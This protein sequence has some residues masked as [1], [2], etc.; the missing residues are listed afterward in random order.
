M[1]EWNVN[2]RQRIERAGIMKMV[3]VYFSKFGNTRRVAE[4]MGETLG[5]AGEVRVVGIDELAGVAREGVDLVVVG[6]P[7]HA[8][9]VPQEVGRVLKAQ[10]ADLLAGTSVAAFDT[11]VRRWPFR[12]LRAS[13]KLLRHLRRLGGT[14]V[15]EPETFFVALRGAPE[16][17]GAD[18]LEEG[19]I[20]RARQWAAKLLGQSSD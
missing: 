3:I 20:D 18:L 9:T 4:A 15:A 17:N 10:R 7:T 5:Q 8:F 2:I 14:P 6:T 12:H 1:Q 16:A 11:T 19:Q 13:P